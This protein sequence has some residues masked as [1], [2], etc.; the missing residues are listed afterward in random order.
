MIFNP[1]PLRVDTLASDRAE[2]TALLQ[3]GG[4]VI[5][6]T[7]SGALQLLDDVGNVIAKGLCTRSLAI[8]QIVVDEAS[9]H[10]FVLQASA[11]WHTINPIVHTAPYDS[12]LELQPTLLKLDGINC[13]TSS[14][15]RQHTAHLCCAADSLLH[16]YACGRVGAPGKHVELVMRVPLTLPGAFSGIESLSWAIDN[17]MILCDGN[18]LA[19]VPPLPCL[20]TSANNSGD[21]TITDTMENSPLSAFSVT[22]LANPMHIARV[23]PHSFHKGAGPNQ[24]G[25]LLAISHV[26]FL[27]T[28]DLVV[29]G[30]RKDGS[31]CLVC[32]EPIQWSVET[33]PGDSVVLGNALRPPIE[34]VGNHV[35]LS[36][37]IAWPYLITT[38]HH[39]VRLYDLY[40]GRICQSIRS[41]TFQASSARKLASVGGFE[42][43]LASAHGLHAVVVSCAHKIFRLDA[44]PGGALDADSKWLHQV[45]L[46]WGRNSCQDAPHAKM[47]AEPHVSDTDCSCPQVAARPWDATLVEKH[48]KRL[49]QPETCLSSRGCRN[50]TGNVGPAYSGRADMEPDFESESD[51]IVCHPAEHPLV[52]AIKRLT[53]DFEAQFASQIAVTREICTAACKAT[54]QLIARLVDEALMIY[55]QLA[56]TSPSEVAH[57]AAGAE[58][59][60]GVEIA[61]YAALR[62][63]LAGMHMEVLARELDQ[64]QHQLRLLARLQPEHLGL[65]A[66]FTSAQT[67]EPAQTTQP[68]STGSHCVP[69]PQLY[70]RP[71]CRL[72]E[73]P[74]ASTPGRALICLVDTCRLIAEAAESLGASPPAADE[75][76]P[77]VAFA[78]VSAKVN[79]ETPRTFSPSQAT[80]KYTFPVLPHRSPPCQSSWLCFRRLLQTSSLEGS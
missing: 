20:A 54:Q 51:S 42:N 71:I 45:D 63:P 23:A 53:I 14:I 77:L 67:K 8:G 18:H 31:H 78:I 2:I 38:S 33:P 17:S 59:I 16:I 79:Y 52:T 5:L 3:L 65:P 49:F 48:L 58:L 44:P 25:S 55:P 27:R 22:L 13:M 56:A 73:L 34:L 74:Q 66:A 75:L 28:G 12:M 72:Q 36:L 40:E 15:S 76:V 32:L 61:G 30:C 19:A 62:K 35:P 64:Y 26:S 47:N 70:S 57:D 9:A 80:L 7:A 29:V 69:N 21:R 46:L 11:V 24:H 43:L 4:A 6:G 50:A 68:A 1:I 10:F 37:C 41:S 39:H 60:A